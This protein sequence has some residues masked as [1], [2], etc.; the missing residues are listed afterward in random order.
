MKLVFVYN[1]DSGLFNTVSDIAHKLLSPST[2]QCDLCSL[3]HGTFR[4]RDSWV[5]FLRELDGVETAF[6]H[7]DELPAEQPELAEQLPAIFVERE[8]RLEVWIDREALAELEDVEALI[9]LV[10]RRL[11][12]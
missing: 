11:A 5:R 3:T 9:A 7:R 12:A 10:R 8:G 1:A 4:V 2:Y 6:L